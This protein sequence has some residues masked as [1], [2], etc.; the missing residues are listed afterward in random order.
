[1]KIATESS[2]DYFI[3]EKALEL[4]ASCLSDPF[5]QLALAEEDDPETLE[6]MTFDD[7]LRSL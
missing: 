6:D 3:D 1:M 4:E 5:I 2:D 7:Y